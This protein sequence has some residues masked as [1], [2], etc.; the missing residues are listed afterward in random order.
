[1]KTRFYV[2]LLLAGFS[3]QVMGSENNLVDNKDSSEA[4][5][6]YYTKTDPSLSLAIKSFTDPELEPRVAKETASIKGTVTQIMQQPAPVKVP[7]RREFDLQG[8][9]SLNTNKFKLTANGEYGMQYTDHGPF[10]EEVFFDVYAFKATKENPLVWIEL[11]AGKGAWPLKVFEYVENPLHTVLIINDHYESNLDDIEVLRKKAANNSRNRALHSQMHLVASDCVELFKIPQLHQNMPRGAD[12]ISA[13]N[14]AHYCSPRKVIE[15]FTAVGAHL[16]QGGTFYLSFDVNTFSVNQVVEEKLF[17]LFP[18]ERYVQ[19][20]EFYKG[21]MNAT[22]RTSMDAKIAML[23]LIQK[24]IKESQ[25]KKGLAFPTYISEGSMSKM[26]RVPVDTFEPSSGFIK[27]LADVTG[28]KIVKKIY[29]NTICNVDEL[30]DAYRPTRASPETASNVGY[31]FKRVGLFAPQNPT[32][33]ALWKE[34]LCADA[35]RKNL[36]YG[37]AGYYPFVMELK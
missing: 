19:H 33:Q 34:A 5:K 1:M 12:F 6:M 11:G 28:L 25:K 30:A 7:K 26:S 21:L 27:T 31:I 20:E 9:P 8:F 32:F 10:G 23:M 35:Q 16:K 13:L 37:H 15:I 17:K 36:K 22:L 3:T 14:L 18:K 29:M 4:R 24:T 2:A